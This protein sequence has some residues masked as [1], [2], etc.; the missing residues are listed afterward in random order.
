[1]TSTDKL[2][3]YLG[4]K[5]R[6]EGAFADLSALGKTLEA[7]A[8]GLQ[9]D[10]PRLAFS[11]AAEDRPKLGELLIDGDPIPTLLPHDREQVLALPKLIPAYRE[12]RRQERSA[13]DALPKEAQEA[14]T[15]SARRR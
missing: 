1:M 6:R 7:I 14:L 13:F 8:K 4:A 10:P 11:E 9:N 15:P 12:L 3:D 2:T 5:K